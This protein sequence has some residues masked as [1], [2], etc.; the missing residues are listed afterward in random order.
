MSIEIFKTKSKSQS[1]WIAWSY[2]KSPSGGFTHRH[3]RVMQWCKEQ[4]WG[5]ELERNW[6]LIAARQREQSRS[7]VAETRA[8]QLD[9]LHPWPYLKKM[10]EVVGSGN[11]SWW[12][13]LMLLFIIFSA[14]ILLEVRRSNFN[15]LQSKNVATFSCW[16]PTTTKYNM[17]VRLPSLNLCAS[18]VTRVFLSKG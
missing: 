15:S 11:N 2:I 6:E 9:I 4:R 14:L 7:D 17:Y 16:A 12:L 13:L 5:A 18:F 8:A 10:F 3:R 1:K